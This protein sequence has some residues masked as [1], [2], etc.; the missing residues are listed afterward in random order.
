MYAKPPISSFLLLA[1]ITAPQSMTPAARTAR[2]MLQMVGIGFAL[3]CA[4]AAVLLLTALAFRRR[5]P[6]LRPCARNGS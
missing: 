4:A 6:A 5:E 1:G 2:F 3:Y